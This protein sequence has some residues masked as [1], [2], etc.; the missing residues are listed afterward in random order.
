VG[1]PLG[2]SHGDLFGVEP[3]IACEGLDAGLAI[4]CCDRHGP[5]QRGTNENTNGLLRQYFPKGTD[6]SKHSAD[7]LAAVTAAHNGPA[8]HLVGTPP[9]KPWTICY[10]R[11]NKLVLRRLV[12]PGPAAQWTTYAARYNKTIRQECAAP[13][14][15]R[16]S[17]LAPGEPVPIAASAAKRIFDG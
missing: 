3:S 1:G 17:Q 9:Q 14:S 6:L 15:T 8:R 16:P 13:S 5:W 11:T 7:D 4:Y 10:F 2:D 12:E